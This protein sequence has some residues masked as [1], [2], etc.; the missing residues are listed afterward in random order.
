[1]NKS[2]LVKEVSATAGISLE[3]AGVAVE[4]VLAGIKTGISKDGET[5][6]LGFGVFKNTTRAAREGRNP[7]TGATIQIPE[8]NVVKFKPYF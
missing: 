6:V 4:S 3:K 5:K 1:M 8:K 7:S 2:E